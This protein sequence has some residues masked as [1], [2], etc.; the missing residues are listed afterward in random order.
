MIISSAGPA[1]VGT[2]KLKAMSKGCTNTDLD[3]EYIQFH[4]ETEQ[5]ISQLI[6]TQSTS[7]VMLGEALLS[8]EAACY[9]LIEE[10]DR[11]LVIHNGF[12]GFCF[13]DFVEMAGGIP[14]MLEMDYRRGVNIQE[15]RDFLDK[16]HD[17]KVATL[18]HCETPS[19]ITNPIWELCPLLSR[20]GI[21][22]VVDSV[23]AIGGEHIDFDQWK[24]DVLLGGSQKCFSLPSGLSTVTVSQKAVDAM[25]ERKLPIRSFYANLK[26]HYD[27]VAKDGFL[28]T[29]NDSLMTA[30]RVSLEEKLQSDYVAIHKKFG[31]GVRQ[32]FIHCGYELY[33][34]DHYSNTVTAVLL[35][36]AV[37][38]RQV[39]EEM[40][41]EGVIISGGLGHLAGKVIRI[42]HMGDNNTI[43]QMTDT[44]DALDRVFEKMGV[45]NEKNLSDEFVL[46]VQE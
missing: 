16:D 37:T 38:D 44:L 43:Q 9:S 31:N 12:F 34:M 41:R 18:V 25:N 28:Y 33:P 39:M 22:S 46:S 30:L 45:K 17:F 10:G 20:Y 11:V 1:F 42:G 32:A 15:L 7:F 5:M 19:G 8:L 29:M 3:K 40:V 14:V 21:I 23:S 2:E 4:K 6:G 27:Y 36:Q 13:K 24:I 26:N 35:P